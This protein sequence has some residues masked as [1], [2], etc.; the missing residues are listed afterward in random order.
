METSAHLPSEAQNVGSMKSESRRHL[1]LD[2]IGEWSELKLDILKKYAGAYCTILK[3]RNLHPIYI[4]GFA[5]AGTHIRKRTGELVKGSPLNALEIQ[6]PFDELHLIDIDQNKVDALKR[7]T[8]GMKQ[9]HVYAGD[10]NEILQDKVFPMV[11]YEDF[12]RGLCILDP[13]G[14]HLHCT[15]IA[16]AAKRGTVEIFLNFPT[17]DMNRNVL[18]WT[19]ENASPEDIER[20]NAFWGDGS[21]RDVA[22]STT[23]NLFGWPE[24]QPNDVIAEAFRERLQKVAGFKYVP[25]PVRMRNSTSAILYYLF[26]AA[27]KET[28]ENIVVDILSKYRKQGAL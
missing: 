12:R 9:V 28:A 10:A 17:L 6:P 3:A 5:G 19:P 16:D 22:Y 20:M 11:K 21:W 8:A 13:Y 14:L 18:L 7:Q 26:F 4:D 1:K 24:K 25:E 2:E 27:Q 15:V 23:G